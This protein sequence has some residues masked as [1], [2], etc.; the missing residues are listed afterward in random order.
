MTPKLSIIVPCYNCELTLREAV[1]SCYAQDLDLTEF[2]VVMVDDG[3]KDGT[4]A[5]MQQL[6][7]E[8]SNIRLFFHEVN[9]GGGAARN[10]GIR[11][12]IGEIIYC[13]DSD[14]I[15][16]HKSVKSILEYLTDTKSDGAAYYE[17]RFFFG[18]NT[19]KF[20]THLNTI[21]DRSI[22]LIDLFTTSNTLLDNFFYTKAS[23]L[24]TAGYPEHHGF[25]TQCFEM[26]YLAAGNTVR[27][28]PD[29]IFYHRQA[30]Q[31]KSYFERV[32]SSGMFSVNFMLIFEDIF[33]LFTPRVQQVLLE[34]PLFTANKSYGENILDLVKRQVQ[35]GEPVFVSDWSDY[36]STD[37]RIKWLTKNPTAPQKDLIQTYDYLDKNQPATALTALTTYINKMQILTP[38]LEFLSLR[39]MHA[40]SGT[41]PQDTV[42]KTLAD[43]PNLQVTPLSTRGGMIAV[44]LRRHQRIYQTLQH[45]SRFFR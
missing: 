5:L 10:T 36:L 6:A 32:H 44:W 8:H 12:A 26:R 28:C 35:A 42:K 22:T 18:T 24:K 43:T 40:L 34:F 25:D 41:R 15:F 4:R 14:N 45:L 1:E 37:S 29:S 31:E 20:T 33:H 3:S 7:A 17:R 21:T 38:Y 9:K 39:I 27:V 19:K 11:E 16:A 23:Y 30:M 13:L 2:E